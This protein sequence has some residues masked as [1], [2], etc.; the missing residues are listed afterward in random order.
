M[1]CVQ[2]RMEPLDFCM[3][4]TEGIFDQT[5]CSK[6]ER[7]HDKSIFGFQTKQKHMN[8]VAWAKSPKEYSNLGFVYE[9][10]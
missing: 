3:I 4:K 6:Y 10:S 2:N 5:V 7:Q 9:K 8:L 1:I